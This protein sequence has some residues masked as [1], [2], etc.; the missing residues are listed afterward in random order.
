MDNNINPDAADPC[1]GIDQN[2]DGKADELFDVD[3]DN[4]TS[5][6]GDCRDNDATSF[7]GAVE[8]VDG[9]DNDCDGLVDNNTSQS[10]DDGDGFSEDQ[11]D[12]NDNPDDGGAL[13]GPS[14][15][16]VALTP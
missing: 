2:C 6:G 14:A 11:G 12:C 3:G 15:I 16:E 5:C 4:F 10:D 1:D 8:I 9:L 7:P 13:I